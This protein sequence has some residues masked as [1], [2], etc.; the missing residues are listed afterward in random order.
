MERFVDNFLRKTFGTEEFWDRLPQQFIPEMVKEKMPRMRNELK[1]W[2]KENNYDDLADTNLEDA[3]DLFFEKLTSIMAMIA[4]GDRGSIRE[5]FQDIRGSRWDENVTSYI[6]IIA[7][8][9][10]RFVKVLF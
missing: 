9:L 6:R 8:K 7:D 2:L 4:E 10:T 1:S 3:A 5:L